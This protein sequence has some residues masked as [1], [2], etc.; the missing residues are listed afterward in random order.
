MSLVS[1]TFTIPT[2]LIVVIAVYLIGI[3][4][5]FFIF[6]LM[7][8]KIEAIE[9]VVPALVWPLFWT[10][11][12]ILAFGDWCEEVSMCD[13][14]DRFKRCIAFIKR[15][16]D[17]STLPIRPFSFGKKLSELRQRKRKSEWRR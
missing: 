10:G 6:G 9:T 1:T 12:C 14:R 8:W 17:Y 13:D 15:L 3:W 2:T 4:V 16:I 5:S 11:A 7:N